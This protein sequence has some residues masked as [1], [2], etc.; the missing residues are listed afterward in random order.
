MR[1]R[2]Q[3]SSRNIISCACQVKPLL[4]RLADEKFIG[5]LQVEGGIANS[6]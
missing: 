2:R 6:I 1:R 4:W 5:G 3:E